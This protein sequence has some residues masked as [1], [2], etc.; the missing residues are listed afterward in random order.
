MPEKKKSI[1][2]KCFDQ[3][4]EN[5]M[6]PARWLNRHSAGVQKILIR[7]RAA[8]VFQWRRGNSIRIFKRIPAAW[9]ASVL[10]L[11]FA[12]A[13]AVTV[14]VLSR[15]HNADISGFEE[16]VQIDDSKL[17][18]V[19]ALPSG[20]LT[21]ADT[22][23]EISV[24]FNHPIIPL[25]V[26]DE[27]TSGVF[28]IEP[29]VDGNFRWYGSRICSFIPSKG[30]TPGIEY[31][32]TVKKGLKSL[33]DRLLPD[34]VSFA[35]KIVVK[36]LEVYISPSSGYG[37]IDYNQQFD[38][39]FS[40][41]VEL[42][43]VKNTL[44]LESN[45][46]K[47][48]YSAEYLTTSNDDDYYDRFSSS[49]DG[50]GLNDI[51]N[52][53]IRIR[54]DKNFPRDADVVLRI[55]SSLKSSA[56]ESRMKGTE[57]EGFKTHG[58]LTVDLKD[59]PNYFQDM[60]NC[61]LEFNNP[62][63]IAAAVHAVKIDP[64]AKL[65]GID[66]GNT[67]KLFLATWRFQ[68]GKTYT[69]TVQPLEDIYG[70]RLAQSESFTVT[71][72]D[73][74]P[75]FDL[76][77]ENRF[78]VIESEMKQLL[79][80]R[81][82]NLPAINIS[83]GT[84]G[85]R[86]LQRQLTAGYNYNIFD[87]IA[88]KRDRFLTGISSLEAGRVGFDLSKYLSKDKKGW[89]AV[90]MS[91][92]IVDYEGR[93]KN[94]SDFQAVQSTDLGLTVKES[95]NASYVW[96]NSIT[97]GNPVGGVS[98]ALYDTTDKLASSVTDSSGY[99]VIRKPHSGNLDLSVYTAEKNDGDKSYV[100]TKDH[101]VY[102]WSLS[103]RYEST[104]SDRLLTGQLF[105]DRRLYR[106]GD[107]VSFKAVAAVRENGRLS[108][109]SNA[110]LEIKV[111]NVRGEEI[112]SK[113][114]RASAQGGVWG[115][116]TI[117]AGAPLGHYQ[118]TV[119]EK[120]AA[121]KKKRYGEDPAGV[122]D[123]FQVEEFRPVSFSVDLDGVKDLR[124]GE[125]SALTVRGSY[126]FGAAMGRAPV[127]YTFYRAKSVPAPERFPGFVF[128]DEEAAAPG[129]IDWSDA[130]LYTTAD[131]RLDA[132][133][134]LPLT[135][136]FDPMEA[137]DETLSDRVV[138]SSP[139][140][141]KCEAVVKDVDDRSVTKTEFFSVYP[142]KILP[143]IKAAQRYQNWQKPFVFDIAAVS[144]DGSPAKGDLEIRV[145]RREWKSILT[146]GADGTVQ[147]RNT[148]ERTLVKKDSVSVSD[149]PATFTFNP[150]AP[151]EYT[152]TVQEKGG[153]GFARIGIYAFGGELTSWDFR[154]DDSVTIVP[155][156]KSYRPGDTA[157]LL[158]KSPF[159][160]C[161]A[162]VTLE[163]EDVIWQKSIDLNDTGTPVAIPI[164]E[165]YLP[166]VFVSVMLIRP[167]VGLPAGMD[168]SAAKSFRENDLGMP[169][170]KVGMAELT[171][172]NASR[173]ADLVVKT[174]RKEYGPGDRVRVSIKTAPNAEIALSVADRG[175]LD[176]VGYRYTN[177]IERI[178]RSWPL[179]V[180]IFE[181]RRTLIKQYVFG[182]K[183]GA[184]P[185]GGGGKD[186]SAEGKGGFTQDSE[187]G[188][189]KDI[190]YT[191]YWK[192][193][194]IADA[195][196]NAAVEFNLPHNLTTFRLMAVSSADGKYRESNGEIVVRKSVVVRK[197][198]PR[199]I[200]PGDELMAGA[201]VTNQ[202]PVAA[203]FTVKM[204]SDILNITGGIAVIALA[205]GE[206]KEVVFPVTLD[207]LRYSAVKGAFHAAG[208]DSLD[209]PVRGVL[210]VTPADNEPFAK[211]GI[212]LSS[213]KDS[214]S[215]DFP[216]RIMQPE[217][218]FSV[219][220]FTEGKAREMMRIPSSDKVIPGIGG[221]TVTLS[222][223]ALV[224]IDKAFSFFATNP[225]Y[226]IE[227]RASA[228]LLSI[229]SGSLLSSF[230][231]PLPA[232]QGYDFRT[233]RNLFIG[234]IASF[235]N[236]DGGFRFWK[237]HDAKSDP[238]LTA[239]VAWVLEEASLRGESIPSSALDRAA[240]YLTRYLAE[241]QKD[242]Y[243]YVLETFSLISYTFALKGESVSAVNALLLSKEDQLSLRA[244]AYL[245]MSIAKDKN[246]SDYTTN[247]DTKRLV[248]SIK[249]RIEITTQKVSFKEDVHGAYE[250][251]FY[252]KGSTLGVL[253]GM[254]MK[255]D[256]GNPLIPQMITFAVAQKAVIFT[257]A[258]S[259]G[260]LALALRD[261]HEFFEKG[262]ADSGKS[263]L[264]GKLLSEQL[265]NPA[266]LSVGS[267]FKGIDALQSFGSPKDL[268][269]LDFEKSGGAGRLYY[270]AS[271]S[272]A[273]V[274]AEVK[275]RDEGIEVHRR[276][277][278]I[279]RA[280]DAEPYGP[281]VK[282]DLSRG[283]IYLCRV[284]V[285][286][287]K[288][289]FNALIVDPLPSTLEIV[290]TAFRT[291]SS[292]AA[293]FETKASA[294]RFWWEDSLPV[295]EYRDDRIV[296]TQ[297]YLSPGAHDFFYLVRPSVKGRAAAPA[298]FAKLMYEPEIFGRTDGGT[299]VVK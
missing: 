240:E 295:I 63:E 187:D 253:I 52:R 237:E 118:V 39:L 189:R 280:T 257:D 28:T 153:K 125:S 2:L 101:Q 20:D 90:H 75:Y 230:A 146:K 55:D 235:Q 47:F 254:M 152:V 98:V 72:P 214:L 103:N 87:D 27:K 142:G 199:F 127:K 91:A 73:Y 126:L 227:Q 123:S 251:A 143:G 191:A 217:E 9:A 285:V 94:K 48:S 263:F 17:V 164:K 106:P 218:A 193:D 115:N 151:G 4:K 121:Q 119:M 60:Y 286:C 293:K 139:Y 154:D 180:R 160:K 269:P 79:P 225:Y 92:D 264:G 113:A 43:D 268:L 207:M 8:A 209:I 147:N 96:V 45:G 294:S 297:D 68:P 185:G 298:A 165:E 274:L 212:L 88:V 270:T 99:C 244:K 296:I 238:Y 78:G 122:I 158:V 210:S 206:S 31:K 65:R 13:A 219:A 287:P 107:E 11:S 228:Y 223:T 42:A 15:E 179:G 229:T 242:G 144:N 260:I 155:D 222:P 84:F 80:V 21:F 116:L 58:P 272:Y 32:V 97:H 50:Q 1:F 150:S 249:N 166:N 195:A 129:D 16:P 290:N 289:F 157:N 57:K 53:R 288:P 252:T 156:K 95:A 10:V 250:R 54:P 69:V 241:P 198:L 149:K 49:D 236:A 124:A 34:D 183:K 248:D 62:V 220:G 145:I 132:N 104:A 174:D 162:I 255:L 190:R 276:I 37:T 261:Y 23:K 204:E 7:L 148:V 201:L 215:F 283:K 83:Y 12:C 61:A 93:R 277:C 265:F 26:L 200:R 292:A 178:F 211:R 25:D 262:T 176:I 141:V 226:C 182:Q 233:I 38:L 267:S 282:G 259:A 108:P 19:Q 71:M 186:D 173:K 188:A 89:V 102:M 66:S 239:Y 231:V 258:H 279:S 112:F 51:K 234:E 181:N 59:T 243:S 29:S 77:T 197:N 100:S 224:G 44:T 24:V 82:E 281:I 194:I 299:M 203:A 159:P 46:R 291:E 135:V 109:A 196:G 130:G 81:A 247:R 14:T 18:V 137:V 70:N 35:F 175:I 40:L 3:F 275:A 213:V 56:Y 86:E 76:E 271:L 114:Q 131:A 6:L 266:K 36:P 232:G 208:Q 22:R 256:G 246:L 163:R 202:T 133:G 184:S 245:A 169:K 67:R 284:T 216:V 41:P 134:K 85:V 177:P 278:D 120:G 64:P 117:P 30:W 138:M 161:R 111:K 136:R 171:V 140:S 172:S 33:N 74:R 105:F 205:P 167:R 128:G 221:L 168:A 192:P 110:E 273:P 170:F 5:L